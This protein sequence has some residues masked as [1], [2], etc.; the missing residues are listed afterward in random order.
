MEDYLYEVT[1]NSDNATDTLLVRAGSKTEAIHRGVLRYNKEYSNVDAVL[2]SRH[3]A[4]MS[5]YLDWLDKKT[6]LTN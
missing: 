6:L 3:N 2:T 5:R 4:T 1:F